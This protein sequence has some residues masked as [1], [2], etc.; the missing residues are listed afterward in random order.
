MKKVK[1]KWAKSLLTILISY[2]IFTPVFVQPSP[3]CTGNPFL[4]HSFQDIVLIGSKAHAASMLSLV[5][6]N[7]TSDSNY[8]WGIPCDRD[9]RSD[10]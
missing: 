6:P 7:L 2:T 8:H 3:T 4:T 5:K 9:L 1:A 10:G